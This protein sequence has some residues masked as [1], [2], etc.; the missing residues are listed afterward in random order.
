MEM[1]KNSIR[2][3]SAAGAFYPGTPGELTRTIATMFSEVKKVSLGGYPLALVV[4]HAGYPYSGLTAAR[5]YK[6]L[7]GQTYD[8]VVIVSPS[9]TVFFKGSSVYDGAGYQTPLGVV[10][11]DHELSKKIAEINPR[12]AYFS[13]MGHASG[14]TRGEHALEVQL[15]FLQVV[16]GNFKLVA[17]VM[18][19]QEEES[20]RGL[21]ETLAS[22][23][24]GTNTLLIASSDLSHFHSAKIAKR[25][26]S[27]I[28]SAVEKYDP[29]RLL[30]AIES[31]QGEACGAGPIAAVMRATK[32]LGGT[33][34]EFLHYTTSGETTGDF[35][36]V[37]GYLSAA[38]V[39]DKAPVSVDV[40]GA[41]PAEK[42][43][44]VERISDEDRELLRQIARDAIKAGLDK[45]EYTPPVRE[46]LKVHKGA[47]VT[48][49]M[50]GNLRG[51]IG[52]LRSDDPLYTTIAE[53]A[54]AAAF[55]DPRFPEMT[56]VEFE[57]MEIEISVLSP[58]ERVH[59]FNETEVG[60]DGLMVKL[61]WHSGLLLPQV[62][63]ENGWGLLEFL[64]QTC[65][66]AGLAKHSYRDKNAEVYRFS[67]E[68]F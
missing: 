18:G 46:T 14:S 23:L 61:D 28:Q 65:L 24:R 55:D 21:G 29:D 45:T 44:K 33:R 43:K 40:I 56:E 49:K 42:E 16:L 3:P 64:E 66:K 39:A 19:D 6:L 27:T 54:K 32:R 53:M 2:R 9:H 5:A 15:P 57:S 67:A 62:A 50:L 20:V 60:R 41:R 8:S 10:E 36:E 34:T 52:R 48:I 58:L 17:I 31:G 22:A 38:V 7:E 68:V 12:T 1:D 35:D 59:D 25:L 26:D 37:V 51:C 47:F 30:D 63:T 11:I 4:P 13:N